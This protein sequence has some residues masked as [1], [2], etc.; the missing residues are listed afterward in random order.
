MSLDAKKLRNPIWPTS[1]LLTAGAVGGAILGSMAITVVSATAL[2]ALGITLA[3]G[4]A[5]TWLA[6][7]RKAAPLLRNE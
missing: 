4:L 7:R 3:L 5:G 2:I 6:L 1:L